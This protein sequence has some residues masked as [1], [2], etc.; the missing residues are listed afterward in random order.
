MSDEVLQQQIAYYRARAGEYDEWFYRLKRYDRGAEANQQWFDEAGIV[1]D[2]LH[3]LG[4]VSEA[5]ELACGTGI[6]T[7]ELAKLA[8]HVTAIDA[9]E[10]VLAINRAKLNAPNVTYKQADLF[11][12]Q[13]TQQ[14]DLVFF[15]FWLSH[16]PPERLAP[17][18]AMVNHALKPGGRLFLIDSTPDLG[19][20]AKN[21]P[22]R[23]NEGIYQKRNLNDGNLYTI[24]KIY[25]EPADLEI[26]FAAAGFHASVQTTDHY[27]IYA[28][29]VKEQPDAVS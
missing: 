19:S 26:K 21:S 12:W 11:V 24:V 10:E 16:V 6:W 22:Q 2:A 15:S 27:F 25:Y 13:P 23:E 9:A 28:S 7:Q 4:H 8:D 1:R 3:S 17:F 5:L 18:L 20:S 29:G 14:Y